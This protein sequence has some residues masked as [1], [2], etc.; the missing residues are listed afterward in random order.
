MCMHAAAQPLLVISPATGLQ[1]HLAYM[2]A[3]VEPR[4]DSGV[5]SPCFNNVCVVL[6][7]AQDD[8]VLCVAYFNSVVNRKSNTNAS[9]YNVKVYEC[10][11]AR[12]GCRAPARDDPHGWTKTEPF[13]MSKWPLCSVCT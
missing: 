4:R 2:P 12:S 6:A 13:E 3:L 11:H 7:G 1:A 8:D 10:M 5:G 9:T